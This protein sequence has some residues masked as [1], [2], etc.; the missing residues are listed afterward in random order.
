MTFV[1]VSDSASPAPFNHSGWPVEIEAP[2]RT[3][4]NWPIVNL[5]AASPPASPAC[6]AEASCGDTEVK[7]MVPHGGTDL[8]MGELPL[9]AF[10]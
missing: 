4:T 6:L 9:A 8:R 3:V 10:P 5:S 1:R 2:M 7:R